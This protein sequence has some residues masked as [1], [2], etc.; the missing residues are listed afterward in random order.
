MGY[1]YFDFGHRNAFNKNMK[2][3]FIVI[4][5]FS[6]CCSVCCCQKWNYGVEFGYIHNTFHTTKLKGTGKS[7]FRIGGILNYNFKNNV[8]L[9]SGIAYERKGGTL[10]SNDIASQQITKVDVYNM[11][12]LNLPFCPYTYLALSFVYLTS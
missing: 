4:L 5:L 7:G 2:K 9:E 3:N 1:L 6:L 8:L 10:K 12:Y 11:D